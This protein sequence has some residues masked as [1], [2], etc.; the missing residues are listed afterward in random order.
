MSEGDIENEILFVGLAGLIPEFEPDESTRDRLRAAI[1]AH[2]RSQPGRTLRRADGHW[3]PLLPGIEIKTLRKD[4]ADATQTTL[5]RLQPGAQVPPHPHA[6]D[7]ECL[8]LEGSIALAGVEYFP[9]DYVFARAGEVHGVIDAP[10]GALF[11][12]RGETVPD[13]GDLARLLS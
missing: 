4:V 6:K 3:Q 8:V 12:I 10:R 5:W 9:G 11:L 1:L 2:T 13:P 7:E